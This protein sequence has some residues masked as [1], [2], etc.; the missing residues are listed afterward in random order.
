MNFKGHNNFP[1]AE[2]QNWEPDRLEF[3]VL[4]INS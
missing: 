3:Q 2:N 1:H 4:D